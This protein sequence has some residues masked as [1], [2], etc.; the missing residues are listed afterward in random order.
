MEAILI[1]HSDHVNARK[2]KKVWNLRLPDEL[3]EAK[4]KSFA[5]SSRASRLRGES[6]AQDS[7]RS[8][9]ERQEREENP[10]LPAKDFRLSIIGAAETPRKSSSIESENQSLSGRHAGPFICQFQLLSQFE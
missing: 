7:P 4:L 6:P 3:W 2:F 9:E 10:F 5:F 1:P 8:R